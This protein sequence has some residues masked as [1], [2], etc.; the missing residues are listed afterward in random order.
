M[1]K[2]I[3][4][5]TL[6]LLLLAVG[7]AGTRAQTLDQCQQAAEKNYPLIRQFDLIRQTTD[8]NVKNISKAWLPQVSASAQATLQSD[9]TAFPEQVQTLYRQVGIDMKG[10]GKDQ[11]RLGINLTQAIYDGGAVR[12]Q[13]NIAKRAGEV[14]EAQTEVTLY[15]VRQRVNEMYFA[16]LLLDEQIRLQSDLQELLQS[17]EDKL[18]AMFKRGTAAESDFLSVKAERL[19]VAQGLTDLQARRATTARML[20]TFCGIDV[21]SP[22]KPAATMPAE[23]GLRPELR[24]IDSQIRLA[25]TQE[26]ALRSALLPRLDAFAQGFYGYPG[27]NLFEDMMSRRWSTGGMIGARISWNIGALYTLKNDKAKLQL[28]RQSAENSRNVFLWNNNLQQIQQNEDILRYRRLMADDEDIIALRASVRR[29]AESKLQHGIIDAPDLVREINAENAA[30][31][32]QSIHEIEMLKEI[33]KLK[34]T[35]NK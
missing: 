7:L 28:V 14:E 18:S 24:L 27:Y 11:Y 19:N 32:Q 13:K 16:L 33:Y 1:A 8:L 30:R 31:L 22:I 12:N 2:D 5:K 35:L 17:N 26:K 15:A 34:Y 6:S 3:M 4:R 21:T 25:D 20:S 9:V 10:L 29:A 23:A